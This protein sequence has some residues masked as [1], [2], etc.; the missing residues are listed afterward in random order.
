[1][2]NRTAILI[3]AVGVI[4][5]LCLGVAGGAAAGVYVSQ[6]G[7]RGFARGGSFTPNFVNPAVPQPFGG[8]GTQGAFVTQVD[9]GSPADKAG[10]K[11]G[12]IITAVDGQTVDATHPLNTLISQKK[13]G[14][15]VVLSIQR[16]GQTQTINV[17]LGT[18]PTN[19]TT[20]YLGIRFA[21]TRVRPSGAG[22]TN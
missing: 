1:M 17:T 21:S 20:A 18:S 22:Q 3:A 7:L 12:D 4:L 2:N 11:T 10:L 5:S 8:T 9:S 13:P 15:N 19:S 14:D 16:G 6:F